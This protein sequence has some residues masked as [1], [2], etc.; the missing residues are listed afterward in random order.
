MP[1][2]FRIL[3]LLAVLNWSSAAHAS[4]PNDSRARELYE[5][6]AILYEEGRYQDAIKA[7]REAYLLSG[8][9]LLLYNIANAQ[10]RLGEWRLALE[11]LN[12]YRAYAPASDREMLDRRINNLERRLADMKQGPVTTSF[13][14]SDPAPTGNASTDVV[15]LGLLG[16]GGT[17]LTVGTVFAF[18]ARGARKSAEVLCVEANDSPLCPSTA[19]DVLRKDTV[20]SWV[21]DSAFVLGAVATGLGTWRLLQV[22]SGL[23]LSVSPDGII[24]MEGQF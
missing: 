24:A 14:E 2:T 10:E 23:S 5:N 6:G 11:T 20:S 4:N 1:E 12:E 3:A 17:L 16:G 19:A 21:A 9:P 13:T 8:R 7:W 18:R 15:A 22:D